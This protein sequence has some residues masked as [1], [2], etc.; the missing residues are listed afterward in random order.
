MDIHYLFDVHHLFDKH[1]VRNP[2]I[3]SGDPTIKGT[4]LTVWDVVEIFKTG[5]LSDYS[6]ISHEMVLTCMLYT[7]AYDI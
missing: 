5:E 1:I 2:I 6:Y 4:R 7:A 3:R